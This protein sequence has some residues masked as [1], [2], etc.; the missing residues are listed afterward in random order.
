MTAVAAVVRFVGIGDQ[1]FWVDETV[2]AR[3]VSGSFSDLVSALPRSEST[4]PSTTCSRGAG[5]GC[6]GRA[7]QRCAPSALLGTLTVPV[8]MAVGRELV[9]RRTGLIVGALAAVGPVLVW[10]SQEARAY[11]LFVFLGALSL[12]AFVRAMETRGTTAAARWAVVSALVIATHYF[13]A[14]LIA[15]EAAFLLYRW[16]CRTVVVA[17]AGLA[18]AAAALLPLAAY[19]ATRPRA[20]FARSTSTAASRRRSR[21]SSYR[22]DR[23]SGRARVFPKA[24]SRGGRS[25]SSRSPPQPAPPSRSTGDG[26]GAAS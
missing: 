20:G 3:L 12:L 16:R 10:Y 23:A 25:A 14:F 19:Q 18:A 1:S 15:A 9:S 7:K 6:S 21:S 2:T 4:P 13:G 5:R 8:A 22:A 17:S 24:P 11:A 26:N